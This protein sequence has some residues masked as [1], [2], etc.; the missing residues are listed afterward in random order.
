MAERHSRRF[1]FWSMV[2]ISLTFVLFLVAVFIKGLTHELLQ[3]AG[4]FLVSA[5]LI[6]LSHKNSIA[7]E[8][9]DE[10]LRQIGTLLQTVEREV[11]HSRS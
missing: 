9:T 2:V 1:D 3:E 6:L 5:K 7:V 4:V 11:S 10:H 8:R